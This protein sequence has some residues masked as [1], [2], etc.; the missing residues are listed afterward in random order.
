M[1]EPIHIFVGCAPNHDDAESQAVLEYTVRLYASQPVDITWM[2]LSRDPASP[3]YGWR[4]EQWATP[5]SGF[6]WAVPALRGFHGRAIY[7][8]S[9]VIIRADVAELWNMPF[10]GATVIARDAGRLCVSVWNCD[11]ARQPAMEISALAHDPNQHATRTREY[12]SRPNAV[13]PFS[14]DANWNC[15][16]GETYPSLNHP[17][18][19]AIHYTSIPHQPQLRRARER[20]ARSGRTHWFDGTPSQHWR[21][22]LLDLFDALLSEAELA[23]FTIESYCRDPLYGDYP[24][25]SLAHRAGDPTTDKRRRTVAF[26]MA[27]KILRLI[28]TQPK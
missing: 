15:L 28:R 8:D 14:S 21:G 10:H 22:D 9:D 2:K 19:K 5:F 11:A 24:K 3:F 12:R 1:S 26:S 13:R 7:M 25:Q 16:D 18:I 17:A 23:G 27:D 20:L 4:T 6:R